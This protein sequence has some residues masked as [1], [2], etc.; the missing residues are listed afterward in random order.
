MDE[1]DFLGDTSLGELGLLRDRPP[2][3]CV[4]PAT[5]TLLA[6][7]NMR[8]HG[9]AGAGVVGDKHGELLVN[10]SVSDLRCT[11]KPVPHILDMVRKLC[12]G[13]TGGGF[14]P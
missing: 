6:F 3:L 8:D 5:P 9:M 12:R 7:R 14:C 10:L 1:I 4:S 2:L 11:L 13:H